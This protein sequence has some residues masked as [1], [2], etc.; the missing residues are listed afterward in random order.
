MPLGRPPT[1]MPPAICQA[2]WKPIRRSTSAALRLR[3][4]LRQMKITELLFPLSFQV[5]SGAAFS[6]VGD[7]D[8]H[9]NSGEGDRRQFVNSG[10]ERGW[11]SRCRRP[12]SRRCGDGRRLRTSVRVAVWVL[13]RENLLRPDRP[14]HARI[15]SKKVPRPRI[16][17]LRPM[18]PVQ[19]GAGALEP[20][21]GDRSIWEHAV[22]SVGRS[23]RTIYL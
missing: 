18:P 5:P 22:R 19:V 1:A 17:A 13:G 9:M 8:E 11:T 20:T 3:L 12:G 15:K 16:S 2:F 4:P 14:Q 21:W 6:F 23:H 10:T 7:G